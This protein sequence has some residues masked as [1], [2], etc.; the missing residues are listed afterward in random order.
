MIALAGTLLTITWPLIT[1]HAVL[2]LLKNRPDRY[3]VLPAPFM[4]LV[5]LRFAH[6]EAVSSYMMVALVVPLLVLLYACWQQQRS[7]ARWATIACGAVAVYLQISATWLS[8][9]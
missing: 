4:L 7:L 2:K 6:D 3:L 8:R 1:T 5:V 9:S